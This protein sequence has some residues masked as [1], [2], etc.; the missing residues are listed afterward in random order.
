MNQAKKPLTASTMGEWVED[1]N[2]LAGTDLHQ[3]T[4]PAGEAEVVEG[5]LVEEVMAEVRGDMGGTRISN[6]G[7]RQDCLLTDPR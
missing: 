5:H 6:S 4:V 1:P 2:H 3:A 7:S